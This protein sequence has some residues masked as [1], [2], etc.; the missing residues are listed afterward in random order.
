MCRAVAVAIQCVYDCTPLPFSRTALYH[1]TAAAR[2]EY[3]NPT[4][5]SMPHVPQRTTR[6]EVSNSVQLLQ[7]PADPVLGT[8]VLEGVNASTINRSIGFDHPVWGYESNPFEHPTYQRTIC[9]ENPKY[10]AIIPTSGANENAYDMCYCKGFGVMSSMRSTPSGILL[11]CF[12]FGDV[13]LHSAGVHPCFK[14]SSFGVLLSALTSTSVVGPRLQRES[15][16]KR[17]LEKNRLTISPNV[18]VS[19]FKLLCITDDIEDMTFNVY[20]LPCY[21][22]VLFVMALF[23]F[24]A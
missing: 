18:E 4:Q 22:L 23:H 9:I 1:A 15:P 13:T 14:P 16:H 12:N 6:L 8:Q 5:K 24:M 7:S 17:F 11:R 3:K 21:G 19:F 2:S 10:E 20:A